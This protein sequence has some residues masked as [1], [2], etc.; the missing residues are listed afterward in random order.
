M[1]INVFLNTIKQDF[2]ESCNLYHSNQIGNTKTIYKEGEEFPDLDGFQ[3]A[4]IG[5]EEER[6]SFD[7]KG[8]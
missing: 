7:N 1:E 5:V 6:N 4:I 2:I 8:C 3:L